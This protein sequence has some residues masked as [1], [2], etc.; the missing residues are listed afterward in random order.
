LKPYYG[1]DSVIKK[2]D[3]AT[4]DTIWYGDSRYEVTVSYS[5]SNLKPWDNSEFQ[6]ETVREFDIKIRP[7]DEHNRKKVTYQ[8]SPRWPDQQSKGDSP[9]PSNLDLVGINTTTHG[10]NFSLDSYLPILQTVFDN[11]GLNQQ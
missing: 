10:S 5:K 6:L 2:Y 3:G 11:F 7:I 1:L 9:T 4:T 8:V